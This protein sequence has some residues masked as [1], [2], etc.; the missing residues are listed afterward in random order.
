MNSNQISIGSVVQ[1]ERKNLVHFSSKNTHS[2]AGNM[3]IR[4]GVDARLNM[5]YV[6][7]RCIAGKTP[8]NRYLIKLG[9]VRSIIL[10]VARGHN[11]LEAVQLAQEKADKNAQSEARKE[12]LKKTGVKKLTKEQELDIKNSVKGDIRK[13]AECS[14]S[15]EECHYL[16]DAKNTTDYL[17]T[18][19][20]ID[21]RLRQ[22][23]L[24][25]G[26]SYI[27]IVPLQ[28]IPM[29]DFVYE[30]MLEMYQSGKL[31]EKEE[32]TSYEAL[33]RFLPYIDYPIGG[34]RG[35]M[36][37]AGLGMEYRRFMVM[38]FYRK[39]AS[40][41][42]KASA[43]YHGISKRLKMD[44]ETLEKYDRFI[45]SCT[46]SNHEKKVHAGYVSRIVH[47][48]LEQA[49]TISENFS[50]EEI[51]GIDSD[52]D[53]GFLDDS[54]K[55]PQWKNEFVEWIYRKMRSEVIR[56]DQDQPVYLSSVNQNYLIKIIR[57]VVF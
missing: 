23:L 53:K 36:H 12:L 51:D 32:N 8:L 56:Y 44:H 21:C 49:K 33:Y 13:K 27:G 7:V 54:Q 3:G 37:N 10:D 48:Y 11:S 20:P 18:D 22:I 55:G 43:L 5:P 15:D 19:K 40:A 9:G 24:P 35:K 26:G 17:N 47:Y 52:M 45:Q 28:S 42:S 16:M 46:W 4:V 38:G 39:D 25:D 14:F 57:R 6:S 29:A 1:E 34:D 41:S 50:E 2:N 31:L 30:K